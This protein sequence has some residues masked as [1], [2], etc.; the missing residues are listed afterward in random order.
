[1]D[2]QSGSYAHCQNRS[3]VKVLL[4]DLLY[5][6]ALIVSNEL[7]ESS[8]GYKLVVFEIAEFI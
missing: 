6:L 7:F 8:T 1:M 3:K 2:K 4:K 5:S